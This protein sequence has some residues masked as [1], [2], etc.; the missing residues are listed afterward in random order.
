MVHNPIY[1]GGG[2]VYENH[3]SH[4][5]DT[6]S[7]YDNIHCTETS[8]TFQD[9]SHPSGN[10]YVDQPIHF[11]KNNMLVHTTNDS[12]S[13]STNILNCST[14]DSMLSTRKIAV[15]KNGQERNKLHLTLSLPGND[16]F[17]MK[18]I[19]SGFPKSNETQAEVVDE[20]YTVMNPA[21]AVCL[22][23]NSRSA[24]D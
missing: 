16:S 3:L 12:P 8:Y 5:R 9:N 24:D 17:P 1:D 14:C 11:H 7:Q 18:E 23:P 4:P 10:R 13:T 15:K 6:A 2:P 19:Q 21:G 22:A 20:T